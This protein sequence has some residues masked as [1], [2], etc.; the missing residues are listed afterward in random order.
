ML[1]SLLLM[2]P[3]FKRGASK[4]AIPQKRGISVGFGFQ[5]IENSPWVCLFSDAFSSHRPDTVCG[6][7]GLDLV[8]LSLLVWLIV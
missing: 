3:E 8:L 1:R 4:A 6:H 2:I 7:K 5:E